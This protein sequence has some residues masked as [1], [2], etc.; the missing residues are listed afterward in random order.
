MIGWD[1]ILEGGLAPN[2]AVMSWRGIEGG[3]AAAQQNHD[4]V[5]SPTSFCY[6]DYYQSDESTEPLAIGGFLPMEKVYEFEPIPGGLSPEQAKHILGAQG[7]VWSEKMETEGD[8]EV[9][10]FPRMCALAE[11][12]WSPLDVRDWE[13]FKERLRGHARRL[14]AL[15]VRY[16]RDRAVW[17]QIPVAA[18]W[19]HEGLRGDARP[20]PALGARGAAPRA[21]HC[22]VR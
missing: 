14:D 21:P 15:D 6:F 22:D 18:R 2:A 4:V 7:N 5:M 19:S 3:I 9:R 11:G 1:E 12:L 17:T 10:V 20:C 13:N 8:V 16:Y